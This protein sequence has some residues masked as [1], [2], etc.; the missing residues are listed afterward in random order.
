MARGSLFVL[1]IISDFGIPAHGPPT[2]KNPAGGRSQPA[3]ELVFLCIMYFAHLHMHTRWTICQPL[4]KNKKFGAVGVS[5]SQTQIRVY[6]SA[7]HHCDSATEIS[8]T[9]TQLA[10]G[11]TRRRHEALKVVKLGG[12]F[13]HHGLAPEETG[14]IASYCAVRYPIPDGGND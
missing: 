14:K 3:G 10:R 7:K 8:P 6:D 9:C 13:A 1:S 11:S 4:T 5:T 12:Y 2:T